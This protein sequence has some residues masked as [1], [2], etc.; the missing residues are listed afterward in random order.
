[1][2]CSEGDK[3]LLRALKTLGLTDGMCGYA[4]PRVTGAPH[5]FQIINKKL[6]AL[7]VMFW[8]TPWLHLIGW[9]LVC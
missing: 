4:D 9:S 6:G 2:F 8:S 1:M 5:E 7:E 3:M